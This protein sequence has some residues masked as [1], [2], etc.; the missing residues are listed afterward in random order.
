MNFINVVWM[1][2]GWGG[3]GGGGVKEMLAIDMPPVLC[4]QVYVYVY[5]GKAGEP[6]KYKL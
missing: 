2:G 1:G 6:E 4:V 3:G 5:S